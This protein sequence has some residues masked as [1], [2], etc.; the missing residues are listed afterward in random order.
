MSLE[1]SILTEEQ[2]RGILLNSYG[3]QVQSVRKLPLGSANCFRVECAEGTYFL[4]EYQ[5]E[6]TRGAVEREAAVTE[7]LAGKD[8]PVARFIKTV[9]GNVCTEAEGH[10]ISVQEYIE[11]E[12]YLNDL[13]KPLFKESAKYLGML[14]AALKDYPMERGMDEQWLASFSVED[15]VAKFDRLLSAM[16]PEEELRDVNLLCTLAHIRAD[17]TYKKELVRKLPQWRRYFD[18]ITYTPTH[19]DYTACQLICDGDKVK[20]VIDFSAAMCLPAV[21][22]IMRSYIQSGGACRGGAPFDIDDFVAYVNEYRKYAPLTER[23]LTAMPYVYIYQLSQSSYGYKE[24]LVLKTENRNDLL[25]FAF[26][27]TDICREIER[28]AEEISRAC[29]ERL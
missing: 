15:A 21:W 19:G 8:F 12:S 3:L 1:K 14:H 4:K 24:F 17:L 7:H 18:G 23:D 13:P 28:R 11:G 22:E 16:G 25:R 29:K 6:I 2:M 20:A 26:W 5:S 9:D 10:I 27:R